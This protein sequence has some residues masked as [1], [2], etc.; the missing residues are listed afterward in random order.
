MKQQKF[1]AG[2]EL[3]L[4]YSTEIEAGRPNMLALKADEDLFRALAVLLNV[5]DKGLA[6]LLV[7]LRSGLNSMLVGD[8]SSRRAAPKDS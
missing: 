5:A 8:P 7:E 3:A 2:H 4:I 6:P 1:Y